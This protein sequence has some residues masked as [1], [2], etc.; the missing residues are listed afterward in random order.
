MTVTHERHGPVTVINLGDGDNRFNRD[1]VDAINAALDTVDEAGPAAL[2]TTA[3]GKI[4]SNGLDLDWLGSGEADVDAFIADVH[5]LLLRVQQLDVITVAA[6]N[7]HAFAAGAMF[8]AAHDFA[9]MREDRGFWCLPEA[10]L[11]MALTPVMY[12]AVAGR[13]PQPALGEAVLTGRRY[14]APDALAAG[15]IHRNAPEHELL[16]TAIE[17]A[18]EM[19]GKDRT[20]IAAHKALLIPPFREH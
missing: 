15:I 5:S 3:T 8:T 14:T 19:A 11:G 6:I 4:Y 7:G 12:H 9:F 20:V 16:D 13:V 10:D 1:T 17:Y 18:T 2:V